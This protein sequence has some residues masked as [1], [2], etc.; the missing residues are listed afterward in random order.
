MKITKFYPKIF[1]ET[2]QK[3][4]SI[5]CWDPIKEV[6][7]WRQS[8]KGKKKWQ[9]G[10]PEGWGSSGSL[11]AWQPWRSSVERDAGRLIRLSNIR[12]LILTLSFPSVVS[13]TVFSSF[14]RLF[15][16]LIAAGN[17]FSY[18]HLHLCHWGAH[19]RNTLRVKAPLLFAWCSGPLAPRAPILTRDEDSANPSGADA[20]PPVCVWA[21][22]RSQ[23]FPDFWDLLWFWIDRNTNFQSKDRVTGIIYLTFPWTF[24]LGSDPVGFSWN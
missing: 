11:G 17:S 14:Q 23:L 4:L 6:K 16:W 9:G 1:F 20:A 22:M 15:S 24:Y 7:G 12:E 3:N 18:L 21:L 10:K 8:W 5:P 13:F 2:I 19:P